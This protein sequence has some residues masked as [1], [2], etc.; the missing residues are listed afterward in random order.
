MKM[1]V[2]SW[3]A[4]LLAAGAVASLVGC[5]VAQEEPKGDVVEGPALSAP[6]VPVAGEARRTPPVAPATIIIIEFEPPPGLTAPAA[7]VTCWSGDER[8]DCRLVD[9]QCC[10][11]QSSDN[12]LVGCG[13]C[14]AQ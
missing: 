11:Y 1:K 12:T 13:A 14:N 8:F 2:R 10:T 4:G 7:P 6:A 5:G 9:G 3:I